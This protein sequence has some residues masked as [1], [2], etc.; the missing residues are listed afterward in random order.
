LEH[1]RN[2]IK[3]TAKRYENIKQNKSKEIEQNIIDDMKDRFSKNLHINL[4]NIK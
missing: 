2:F 3:N 4:K 1:W